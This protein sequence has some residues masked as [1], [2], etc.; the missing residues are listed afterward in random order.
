MSKEFSPEHR[1]NEYALIKKIGQPFTI[2]ATEFIRLLRTGKALI[3]VNG[4][5]ESLE[6]IGDNLE[7]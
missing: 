4:D 6:I 2:E 7:E 5:Q 3:Y 1:K